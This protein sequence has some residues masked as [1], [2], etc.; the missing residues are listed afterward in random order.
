MHT[1]LVVQPLRSGSTKVTTYDDGRPV[2]D[3][4]YGFYA[5]IANNVAQ[6][7]PS[8]LTRAFVSFNLQTPIHVGGRVDHD[9]DRHFR[10]RIALLKIYASSVDCLLYTSPSPRDG[11][12][13]RMPSSA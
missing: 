1:V 12:L 9:A 3:E 5:A 11:L 8:T 4:Q 10:G 6:P 2:A 7:T 13:S